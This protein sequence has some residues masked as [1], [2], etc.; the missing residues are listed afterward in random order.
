MKTTIFFVTFLL[1]VTFSSAQIDQHTPCTWMK[2][3]NTIDQSGIYGTQGIAASTNKPGARNF[4]TTWR[5]TTGN[6]WLFGGSGYGVSDFGYLNDLWKYNTVSNQWVWVKGDKTTSQNSVYGTKGIAANANKPGAAYSSASWTDANGNLWLFGG[7]G[8]T[9]SQLGFLNSLWKYNPTSNQWTWVN[10]DKAI[11]VPGVYGTKGVTSSTNK[12]GSRYGS[13]TWMDASGNLWLYGGY[14]FDGNNSG[15]LNDIWKYNPATN[16]WTWIKGD[17]TI[18]QFAVYGTKGI[19]NATNK[20]GARYVS[21]SWTDAAGNFWMFGGYGYDNANAGDLND[22]W[23]Y[24]PS[25]NEWTWVS[26]DNIIDQP[27]VYGTRGTSTNI[28]KPGARYVSSSWTDANG[29]LWLFGG[30]GFDSES[31]VGYMNDLW[32]YH[33]L[34]NR[35]TWVKGDSTVDQTG[36][37]GTQGLAASTNKSGARTGSVSWTDGMG[38]LWLFGGYGFDGNTTGVL[39]DLWKFT[40]LFGVL[41]LHLIEFN[42]VLNNDVVNLKWQSEQETNFSH[43]NIQRSFDGANFTTIGKMDGIKNT[44]KN[45][46]AYTDSEIKNRQ[47]TKAFYRLQMVDRDGRS[48]YSNI[49][50]FNFNKTITGITTFPNPTVQTLNLAFTNSKQSVITISITDVKGTIVKRQVQNVAAGRA[51]ISIDVNQLAAATY[52]VTL[53]NAEGSITQQKFVKQ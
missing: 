31:N 13:K 18:D 3:D 14:G 30:H 51:A 15:I 6:L 8:A 35:W 39:N 24:N 37:Y 19:S 34:T 16:E 42:G 29:N 2:G 33:P 4:G 41:P 40:S 9:N 49:L 10:G 47:V 25:T 20:P 17:N 53:A 5:D 21:T 27:G 48:T 7:F 26:G 45:N 12:P 52:F 1:C 32:K 23:K 50:T 38:N 44:E 43:F 46:Y 11:D 36:V 28:T 22:I